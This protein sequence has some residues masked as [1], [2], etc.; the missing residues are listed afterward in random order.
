MGL[1]LPKK[2]EIR[3]TRLHTILTYNGDAKDLGKLSKE[4]KLK[5]GNFKFSQCGNCQEGCA[6]MQ[7]YSVHDAAVISHSPIGCYANVA[8]RFLGMSNVAPIRG[9][10]FFNHH[11]LCTNIQES[12]TIYGGAKKLRHAV[13]E[14]YKRYNPKVIYITTSCASGI[15]GDDV[16]SVAEEMSEELGIPVFAVECEGFKSRIWSTGFDAAF[17]GILQTALKPPKKKQ[18]DLVNIFNF[19]GV[20]SFTPLLKTIGLR[21]NY[22]VET[23]SVDEISQMSEAACTATICETLATFVGDRLEK[24]YGVPQVISPPPYGITWTDRW[25]RAVASFT[26]KYSIVE[27]AIRKEHARIW[28][29]LERLR[30][31]FKGKK[32]YIF[33]GAAY[34]H[35]MASVCHDLGLEV[36]GIT[37]YHHDQNYDTKDINTVKF[38]TDTIG[39]VPNYT[40]CNK[41]PYQVIK[42]LSK[43]D[44]DFLIV[45]HQA[46]TVLGYKLGIP[47]IMEGDSNKCVGYDGII[48]LGQRIQKILKTR[49]LYKNIASHVE[50]PYTDWWLDE[51]TD[52]FHFV[53]GAK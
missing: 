15:V 1:P 5:I 41:Q 45:R 31:F 42:F 51:K 27:D 19:S 23:R 50:F 43:L 11:S 16:Q 22:L 9:K 12:D 53:G 28:P 26:G 2:V 25:L 29:E 33:S 21:P 52:A 39:N 14:A 47:S 7:V 36:I 6:F 40:I 46:L 10:T 13:E 3:E 8:E 49:K 30:N 38:M 44:P 32:V 18:N 17:N 34:A 35:N 20:D 4:N 48:E 37:T 24:L